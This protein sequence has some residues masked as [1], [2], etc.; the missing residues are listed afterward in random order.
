MAPIL[1]SRLVAGTL[2]VVSGSALAPLI[3]TIF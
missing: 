1:L 2:I 3:Y